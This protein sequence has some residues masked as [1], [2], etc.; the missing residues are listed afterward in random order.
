M[1]LKPCPFC[2]KDIP[3]AI[4]VCPYCHRDEQGKPVAM[5]S[6]AP[7]VSIDEG[8]LNSDLKELASADPFVRDQAVH[9]VSQNGFA[10]VPTLMSRLS[11][12]AKPGSAGVARSLGKIK[13]ARAIPI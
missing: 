4:T 9:R 5:D 10:V 11:D 3:R 7:V 13:D 1:I 6:E 8:A 12:P 2:Q